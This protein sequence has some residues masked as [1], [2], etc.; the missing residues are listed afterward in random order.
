MR[1]SIFC[2]EN[3]GIL[4]DY[5][6]KKTALQMKI[7][8]QNPD[9]IFAFLNNGSE[10]ESAKSFAFYLDGLQIGFKMILQI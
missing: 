8:E 4:S 10:V 7:I 5:F 6:N 1:R 9:C 2:D 3:G